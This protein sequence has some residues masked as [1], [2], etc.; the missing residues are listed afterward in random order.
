M[1]CTTSADYEQMLMEK[2][3]KRALTMNK[4][5]FLEQK[6]SMRKVMKKQ[7]AREGI[8]P[9]PGF[10]HQLLV[11]LPQ[12]RGV[13]SV[14]EITTIMAESVSRGDVSLKDAPWLSVKE[15]AIAAA[16]AVH[17]AYADT[18]GTPAGRVQVATIC[19]K[20]GLAF[21][22]L[23]Q[24][25]YAEQ[26]GS[27]LTELYPN[28]WEGHYLQAAVEWHGH[29]NA[30]DAVRSVDRALELVQMSADEVDD[31][32]MVKHLHRTI[33]GDA[34]VL[35]VDEPNEAKK[36]EYKRNTQESVEQKDALAAAETIVEEEEKEREEKT[37]QDSP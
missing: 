19:A 15:Y 27:Y 31:L 16:A 18:L 5:A 10:E 20:R 32:V 34:V 17:P 22:R 36:E 35:D 11:T 13:G 4:K 25:F 37:Q 7:R 24:Y 23:K 33:H 26:Q 9:L 12:L 6:K 8:T 3:E 30:E 2:K 14:D 28:A 1:G 21:L 29:K